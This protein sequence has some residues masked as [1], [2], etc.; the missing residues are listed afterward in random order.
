MRI[1]F[2]FFL[3]ILFLDCNTSKPIEIEKLSGYWEIDFITQEEEKFK[4]E[5]NSPLYD[6]YSLEHQKGVLNK[7][8][9]NLD[10]VLYSSEDITPFEIKKI[11]KKYYIKFK[12]RWHEWSKIINHLDSQKLILEHNKRTYH[13]KRPELLKF[14][15]EEIKK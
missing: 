9:S 12:S 7:V 5:G 10:G 8:E 2:I 3:F 15:H 1:P 4:P 14:L 11:N 6:H 13:Y